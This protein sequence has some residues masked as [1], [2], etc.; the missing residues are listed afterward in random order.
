[1]PAPS[2]L[3]KYSQRINLKQ[4]IL[5]VI[6]N[7]IAT[8]T[9]TFTERDKECVLSFDE[10]KVESVMEYDPAADEILGPHNYMQ[11]VIAR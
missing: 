6:I 4:G 1:M 9:K 5:D 2:T 8:V 11:V 3:E 7:L 10:M